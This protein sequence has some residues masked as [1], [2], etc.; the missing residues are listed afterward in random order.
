MKTALILTVKNEQDNLKR[1]LESINNQERKPDE[2]VIVDGGSTDDTLNILESYI[3]PFRK[4]GIHY[5]YKCIENLNIAEGRNIAIQFSSAYIIAVTDGGSVLDSGWFKH[6]TDPL[7]RGQADFVGG[8]FKPV[9]H[10]RFQEALAAITTARKPG[11]NFLPSSRSVAFT[12]ALWGKVNGYPEW[13]NWGED[14]LFNKMCMQ[15]GARYVIKPEAVVYWEV[16]RNYREVARQY[17]RYALGDGIAKRIKFS[18][19]GTIFT[20]CV[21]LFFLLKKMYLISSLILIFYP[22]FFILRHLESFRLNIFFQIT[23]LVWVIQL[24]RLLGFIKGI[25]SLRRI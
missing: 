24:A 23:V 19:F 12:R 3:V 20:I 18:L 17:Y 1:L 21:F 15:A 10:S 2:I 16:R 11:K 7:L 14:T 6:I 22:I 13:L 5:I 4:L 25:F 9:G 8:F